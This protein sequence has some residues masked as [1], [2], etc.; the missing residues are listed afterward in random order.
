M[1]TEVVAALV[2]S[3]IGGLLV[4]FIN[5]LFMRKKIEAEIK[6][7]E[8]ESRKANLEAEEI[9]RKRQR[10][11]LESLLELAA[12][13][14]LEKFKERDFSETVPSPKDPG[15]LFQ[16]NQNLLLKIVENL[17]PAYTQQLE[18]PPFQSRRKI[19]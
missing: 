4:A 14:A 2:S 18:Q 6:K 5:L 8:A 16:I 19:K 10:E 3:I 12:T 15:Y 13:R 7:L 11:F 9:E 17:L 1:S